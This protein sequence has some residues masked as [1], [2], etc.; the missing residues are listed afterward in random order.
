MLSLAIPIFF[1][2]KSGNRGEIF[3]HRMRIFGLWLA[4]MVGLAACN[5]AI[6][7]SA[8]AA[9]AATTELTVFAAASLTDA[10]KEIGKNLEVANPGVKLTFN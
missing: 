10:F 1:H 9:S 3:M 4:F 7:P 8:P 6:T 5:L 2:H